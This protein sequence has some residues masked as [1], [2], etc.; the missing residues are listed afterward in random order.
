MLSEGT[1]VNSRKGFASPSANTLVR[2]A[3]SRSGVGDPDG[4][5]LSGRRAA[6]GAPVGSIGHITATPEGAG[7][8]GLT[9]AEIKIFGT[10]GKWR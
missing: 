3:S 9:K 7:A 1:G 10:F 4:V 8:D 6:V 5:T 2:F